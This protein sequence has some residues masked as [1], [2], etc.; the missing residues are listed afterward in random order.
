LGE[1]VR[2]MQDAHLSQRRLPRR[3]NS[4]RARCARRWL[5]GCVPC[6]QSR[7]QGPGRTGLSVEKIPQPET[8]VR[9]GH[10][11]VAAAKS[12]I[13]QDWIGARLTMTLFPFA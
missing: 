8:H 6:T 7:L 12:S 3:S 2:T 11:S 9:L 1:R 5:A 4:P 10:G 13:V